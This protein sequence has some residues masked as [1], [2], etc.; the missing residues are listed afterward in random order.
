M[1]FLT[2]EVGFLSEKRR[3]NVALTRARRHLAVVC[4]SETVGCDEFIKDFLE[5]VLQVGDVVSAHDIMSGQCLLMLF[6]VI[7]LNCF[8]FHAID[9]SIKA[10][11]EL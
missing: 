1:K 5:Y 8:I 4:D 7:R 11:T 2:G 6:R 9:L 10:F 3:I